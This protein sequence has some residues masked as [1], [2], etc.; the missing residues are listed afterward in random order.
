MWLDNAATKRL[1]AGALSV[2]AKQIAHQLDGASSADV[3]GS[4]PYRT[5]SSAGERAC[6]GCG[7]A[8]LPFV[9]RSVGITIDVCR[10]H[11]TWFDRGEVARISL[12]FEMKTL[13][14]DSEAE[15]FG[16]EMSA[17]RWQDASTDLG[18]AR[19]LLRFL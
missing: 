9:V 17:D 5:S 14:D 6:P 11:G 13:A 1:V 4:D 3:A 12:H 7:V 10:E 8:L 16:R 18:L 2:D 19:K 15:A